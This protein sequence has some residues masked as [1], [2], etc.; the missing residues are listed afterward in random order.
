MSEERGLTTT[1][2]QSSGMMPASGMHAVALLSEEEFA[3]N[4]SMLQT[5]AERTR[6]IQKTLMTEGRD[7]GVIPGT[8][9][10]TLLKPGAEI[11][12]LAYGFV[13][14][15]EMQEVPGD[16]V[17][18]PHVRYDAT[19]YVHA[20]AWNGPIVAVGYGTCNGWE[21]KYRWRQTYGA[22]I[23]PGCGNPGLIK[24]K[25]RG[26]RPE[27]YW[28]PE[29]PRGYE[30]GSGCGENFPI[31]IDEPRRIPGEIVE[32][33]DPYDLSNTILKIAEKRGAVDGIL[34]ATGTSGLFTVEEDDDKKAEPP[35]VKSRREFNEWVADAGLDPVEVTALGR[36]L[37]PERD[38]RRLAVWERTAWKAI[39]ERDILYATP[40]QRAA[41]ATPTAA[42]PPAAD[43]PA[44]A[45]PTNVTP[46]TEPVQA[47]GQPP[48]ATSEQADATRAAAA[49]AGPSTAGFGKSAEEVVAA[50][51]Q[52]EA[53]AA[54]TGAARLFSAEELADIR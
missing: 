13:M 25:A 40:E 10:P 5:S 48:A 42:E 36:K 49:T 43:Q 26:N 33:T 35:E 39:A 17:K 34:R 51:Q 47:Q 9:K 38:L 30:A 14:R 27:Q 4:L 22:T 1:Q 12:A 11:L 24:T 41:T 16:G 21:K 15:I 28:H 2:P 45:P 3:R 31:T 7:Y 8:Q 18:T 44:S 53:A 23:C 6:Q 19:C 32:N 46:P 54:A 20:G 29:D 50:V 52:G 37:Y